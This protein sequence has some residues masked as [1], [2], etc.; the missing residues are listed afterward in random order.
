MEYRQTLNEI[1]SILTLHAP[2]DMLQRNEFIL[3][4]VS[5]VSNPAPGGPRKGDFNDDPENWFQ[6][7][8]PN[9]SNFALISV[10]EFAPPK[11]YLQSD[12][13]IIPLVSA[14]TQYHRTQETARAI[15]AREKQNALNKSLESNPSGYFNNINQHKPVRNISTAGLF[16]E[17]NYADY[18]ISPTIP[19]IGKASL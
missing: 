8:R 4:F 17:I 10:Y 19:N 1:F 11:L 3:H 5:E 18:K 16:P 15:L 6:L 14:F 2:I 9:G 13:D 7:R 12:F